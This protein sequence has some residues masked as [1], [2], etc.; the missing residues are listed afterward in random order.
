[1]VGA[2]LEQR[3]SAIGLSL[4]LVS[5]LLLL[6]IILR[7]VWLAASGFV[8]LNSTL[9][10][11]A[12]PEPTYSTWFCIGLAVTLCVWVLMRYGLLATVIGIVVWSP[13][14]LAITTDTSVFHFSYGLVTMGLVFAIAMYGFMTSLAGRPLFPDA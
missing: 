9:F 3:T 1:L 10:G 11:L 12:Q 5:V 7:S 2:L 6:R 13:L 8:V 4:I 14:T